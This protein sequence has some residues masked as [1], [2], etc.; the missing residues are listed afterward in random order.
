MLLCGV[1]EIYYF[2]FGIFTC[3]SRLVCARL[4]PPCECGCDAKPWG[5]ACVGVLAPHRMVVPLAG[6]F[7]GCR[8][9]LSSSGEVDGF[10]LVPASK[11]GVVVVPAAA[12][13]GPAA[14]L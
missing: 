5:P 7:P 12:A 11:I 8:T 13:A 6:P 3:L 10:A 14:V 1:R 4:L 9:A 2:M